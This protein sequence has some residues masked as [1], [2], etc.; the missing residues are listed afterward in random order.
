VIE[1]GEMERFRLEVRE[2][3]SPASLQVRPGNVLVPV[4]DPDSLSHLQK[5]LDVINPEK[6]EVVA[7]SVNVNA[8]EQSR[9][10]AV[11]AEQVVDNYETLVFSRVVHLAEKGGKPVSLVAVAGKEPYP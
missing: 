10:L 3:L 6:V 7:L 5:V 2:N 8:A 1:E 9:D 11:Q 4:H